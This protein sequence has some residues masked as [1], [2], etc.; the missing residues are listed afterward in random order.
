MQKLFHPHSTDIGTIRGSFANEPGSF[1]KDKA[2]GLK[3]KAKH[4]TLA[5]S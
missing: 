5:R 2:K 3:D 1:V 4:K